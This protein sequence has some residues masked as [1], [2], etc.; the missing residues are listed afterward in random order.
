MALFYPTWLWKKI[1]LKLER[2]LSGLQLPAVITL[3]WQGQSREI[4]A[5][6]PSVAPRRAGV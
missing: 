1:Q 6:H 4:H 3:A 5:E 2:N